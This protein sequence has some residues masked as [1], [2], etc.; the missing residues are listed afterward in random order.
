MA[1]TRLTMTRKKH[2]QIRMFDY[3]LEDDVSTNSCPHIRC[4]VMRILG[5]KIAFYGNWCLGNPSHHFAQ[6]LTVY[7]P[8]SVNFENL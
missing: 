3:R 4:C 5:K 2:S 6:N 8:M 1:S 7:D